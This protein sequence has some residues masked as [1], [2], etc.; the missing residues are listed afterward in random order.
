MALLPVISTWLPFNSIDTKAGHQHR[1]TAP[2][3]P[4]TE[5]GF[6]FFF[7]GS[8]TS[9]ELLGHT[10]ADRYDP[11]NNPASVPINTE[12]QYL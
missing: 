9:A 7:K 10:E 8:G 11:L 3:I 12:K 1:A 4:K 5:S 6:F 2:F